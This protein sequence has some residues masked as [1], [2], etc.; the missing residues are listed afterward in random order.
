MIFQFPF[1]YFLKQLDGRMQNILRC[2]GAF[3]LLLQAH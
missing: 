1:F 2:R 3:F